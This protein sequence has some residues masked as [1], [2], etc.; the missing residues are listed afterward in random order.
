MV[1]KFFAKTNQRLGIEIT[2]D[3]I[4]IVQLDRSKKGIKVNAFVSC[5]LP[6]G[7]YQDGRI[8]DPDAIAEVIQQGL[9][10]KKIKLK[11][12]VSA[13]PVGEAVIRL[14][15]LPAELDDFELR[16][17]V[18]N[19]EAALYLPFAREEA[20]VDF[21][22]LDASID[23]DG[24]ERV[25]ILLVATPKEV[26]DMYLNVFERAGLDLEVLEVSS[27]ALL[28][29]LRNQLSQFMSGEAVALVNIDYDGSEISIVVDGV[30]QFNR[31]I[32]IGTQQL[33]TALS[34]A[35]NLPAS[36][37]SDLLQGISAPLNVNPT[38]TMTGDAV[39]PSA[40]A[41]LRMLGDLSDELKRSIDFY[42]N[43]G[44]D[45]EIAQVFLSGVGAGIGQIDEFLSQRLGYATTLVDP[46][47]VLGLPA[48][49]NVSDAQRTSLGI[50]MG[51][52]LKEG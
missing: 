51:L 25:E 8:A 47:E 36:M 11:K 29:T 43:Q 2:P 49:E 1:T 19:Q 7:A 52:G 34:R 32:P 35:M 42:L 9:D 39:N 16:D 13:I 31:K 24:I 21:Q 38:E 37:G 45:L 27:F 48:L 44:E 40:A 28:R 10:E 15:R 20:D 18:L 33:E 3:R 26:T 4:N 50:V 22:K 30:P 14:I 41:I 5:P 12:V 46:L 6:E 23:E 17:M